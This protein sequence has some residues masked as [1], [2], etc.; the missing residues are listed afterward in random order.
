[1]VTGQDGGLSLSLSLV[2]LTRVFARAERIREGVMEYPSPR[3][4]RS[5]QLRSECDVVH[6]LG[7]VRFEA[8]TRRTT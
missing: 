3:G 4:S 6:G 5:P 7:R 8:R 1:M 2:I